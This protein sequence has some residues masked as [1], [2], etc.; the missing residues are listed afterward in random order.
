MKK[1]S[2]QALLKKA[3]ANKT[4][5]FLGLIVLLLLSE[6]NHAE[7]YAQ[8]TAKLTISIQNAPFEEVVHDI[9][10]QSNYTFMY[11]MATAQAIGAVSVNVKRVGIEQILDVT[12]SGKPYTYKIED[13][14]IIIGPRQ[15][16]LQNQVSQP[17]N[18]RG[19]VTNEAG[20]PLPGASVVIKG[21]MIGVSTDVKGKFEI[22]IP[23]RYQERNMLVISFVGM[24]SKEVDFSGKT[25]IN[26]IL[27]EDQHVVADVIVTGIFNKA[28]ESYTGAAIKMNEQELK[29]SGNQNILKSIANIDPSFN[30]V[31][32]MEFGSDPN[33]LPN[34]TMRGRTSMDVNVRDLQENNANQSAANLPLF[35][36]NG[37]EV[38]LQRVMDMDEDLVESI[39]LLKDASATALYG[40]RGANG[41]VIITTK[42]PEAG[43]L[44]VNYRG[45]INIE[46]P[47]F[48]SYNLMNAREKLDYELA[49]G[50]YSS[51]LGPNT[52]Y[53]QPF[54]ELYNQKLIDVERGVDTYWMKY[55]VRTGVGKRHSLRVDGGDDSFKYSAGLSYNNIAGGMKKSKRNTLSG[56]IFFQYELKNIKFQNDLTITDNKSYNSPY[57]TFSDYTL[58]NP[59]YTPYDDEGNL[60]K[61]LNETEV[62]TRNPPTVGNPLYNATLPYKDESRYTNIQNNFAVEWKINS[63]LSVR[64]RFGFTKQEERSDKYL[65]RGH[66]SFFETKNY[67][68]E[69][70]KLRGTYTYGTAYKSSYETDIT[71]NY[72]KTLGDVHQ[73]YAGFN[74][75]MSETKSEGYSINA[76]GFSAENMANLGMAGGYPQDGKPSSTEQHSRRQGALM[77]FNYTYDRRYFADFSGNLEGSSKFGS[78][79]RIA[80]FWSAGLGWNL[81]HEAFLKNSPVV[82]AL[83]LKVSYGTTGSQS[84]SSFQALTTYRYFGNQTYKYWT[85]AYMMGMGNPDLGWQQTNQTNIGLEASLFKNRIRMNVDF[86]EKLTDGLLTDINIPSSSGFSSYKA[87]VGEVRNRGARAKC[88]RLPDP[89]YE[90]THYVVCWRKPD[91]QSEQ[92]TQDIQFIRVLEF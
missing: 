35:I 7:I 62:M 8:Q 45:T 22:N 90:K 71:L 17:V 51:Y 44:R 67:E 84:F 10:S 18:I 15:Q 25:E 41:I 57:G 13:K 42:R 63:D 68:G 1:N 47:D 6:L 73:I 79:D 80:P 76:Q 81:H 83:R 39:T 20:E 66:S 30:I 37:F 34:I 11:S 55:P 52:Y 58:A 46:A 14:V 70:Y 29:A 89:G 36:M 92:N 75:S 31:A 21:T 77:N 86:Y 33:R 40:S 19:Q 74:Y 87:N 4:K 88:Q 48:S 26:V 54:Q 72:N 60:K 2:K 59:I 38:S 65:S 3:F 69:N 85:G 32:N 56:N 61:M 9:E 23:A 78:N 82:E 64:G 43:K 28:P 5:K 24:V 50:L 16:E 12:L 27:H 91:T 53:D 49:A